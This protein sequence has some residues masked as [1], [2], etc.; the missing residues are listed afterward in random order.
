MLNRRGVISFQFVIQVLEVLNNSLAL[1]VFLGSI[2]YIF[3][4]CSPL[5]CSS[6][7]NLPAATLLSY[8]GIGPPPWIGS[9]STTVAMDRERLGHDVDMF[10]P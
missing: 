5:W 4:L 8:S 2:M 6:F 1:S 7:R 9:A 3:Q 10:A